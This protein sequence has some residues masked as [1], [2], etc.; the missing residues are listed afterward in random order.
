MERINRLRAQVGASAASPPPP[1]GSAD[2]FVS[3]R[4]AS[5]PQH[6][7]DAVLSPAALEFVAELAA[8]FQPQVEQLHARR[9]ARRLETEQHGAMPH[10][11]EEMRAIRE[12][13]TWRIDPQPR[14]LMDRRVDIGDVSPANRELLLR[15]LNSGAQG[16]Q[17]DFDD[18]HC[19]TWNNTIKGHFNVL[20]AARGLLEVSGQQVVENP[21]LLVI[22]PRAWNM[23]ES[24]MLV[25]GR[26][27][28]GAL[29][30]FAMHLFHN[31]KHL[32]ETEMGPFLYLPK[33]EGYTEAALWRQIFEYTEKMLDLPHGCI[34]ATVLIENIFAVFEMDEILYELRHHSSGLNCGMWDYTA[35]IV[36]NFRK[37]PECL[38]PDR[39]Q[40]VSMKSDFLRYYMDLLILTCKRRHAPA[41]TG[42]VPFVLSELPTGI[43]QA[44]AIEKATSSKGVE[45]LAGSD[46]ALVYDLALVEPVAT[47]FTE[48][49]E[50]IGKAGRS[51][52]LVFDEAFFAEK[53]LTLPRGDV[54]LKSV[55]MNVRVALLYVLHWLYGNGTVVVNGCIEDSATAEISRAQLW[56]WVYHRVPIAGAS[57]RVDA[58]LIAEMLRKVLH[59]ESKRKPHQPQY[60][61]AARQ[62]VFLISTMRFPPAFI[63]TFLQDQE[64]LVESLQH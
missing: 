28:P 49:R 26:V 60:L 56:Q 40:Y 16:V 22:R 5:C 14:A 45:A 33:L 39:Q 41:T 17:V 46:G 20:Q 44:E 31:G 48:K 62:L 63:T 24:H 1:G 15:A 51:A 32:F 27:V 34:K 25:N 53:L 55:E 38:L 35:S 59:E 13:E 37:R 8:A 2:V 64:A 42:M 6:V 23:D 10:F 47:V 52:P 11:L 29:F 9:Q 7:Y 18:G 21:A 19:P 4:D 54:T 3:L 36:V 50:K 61:E 57:Q 12:D 43:S 58:A 30:D